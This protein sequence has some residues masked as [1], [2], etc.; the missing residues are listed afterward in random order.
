MLEQVG[1]GIR[2]C[3]SGRQP[4]R[5][6]VEPGVALGLGAERVQARGEVAVAAERGRRSVRG[7][8]HRL[9]QLLAGAGAGAA[10]CAAAAAAA[11]G[12]GV[13]GAAPSSTPSDGE[14]AL[15]EAVLALQVLLD[16]APGSAPTRRPG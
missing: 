3:S 14:D 4:E 10:P 15:V 8:L 5:L 12:A 11:A 9:Q 2:A 6:G 7:R 1:A 16:R 13:A